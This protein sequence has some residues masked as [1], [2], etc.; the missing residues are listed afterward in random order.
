MAL[1]LAGY[2]LGHFSFPPL[3]YNYD[4]IAGTE[5]YNFLNN[6]PSQHT[7]ESKRDF[8]LCANI[9]DEWKLS[10]LANK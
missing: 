4:L 8:K 1:L 7:F 2:N 5:F 9:L 3:S 10:P 6:Q